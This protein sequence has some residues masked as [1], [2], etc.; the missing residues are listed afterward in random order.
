MDEQ[1]KVVI[2][3]CDARAAPLNNFDIERTEQLFYIRKLYRSECR[4]LKYRVEHFTLLS[5]HIKMLALCA[6]NNQAFIIGFGSVSLS[7]QKRN[8]TAL[9]GYHERGG[10]IAGLTDDAAAVADIS[11]VAA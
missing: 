7:P 10:A 1:F 3:K 4:L 5:I 9:I 8:P 11:H 6:S 2:L